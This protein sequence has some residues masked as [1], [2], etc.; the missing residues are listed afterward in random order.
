VVSGIGDQVKVDVEGGGDG[1]TTGSVSGEGI[2]NLPLTPYTDRFSEYRDTALDA[3]GRGA[4][5]ASMEDI[6]RAY[7]LELEP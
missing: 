5:P 1:E 4:I 2:E 3:I 7:F 6:V